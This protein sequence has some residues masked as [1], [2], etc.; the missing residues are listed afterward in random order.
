MKKLLTIS[1]ILLASALIF[2]GCTQ[3]TNGE[4]PS[5]NPG[6]G[7]WS[8]TA[9]WYSGTYGPVFENADKTISCG[10]VSQDGQGGAV[11]TN[12]NPVETQTGS[13]VLT[14]STFRSNA[15]KIISDLDITGFEGTAKCTSEHS[16]YGYD[17]YVSSDWSNYYELF[18]WGSHFMLKKRINNTNSIIQNWTSS[19]AIKAE[20]S[21]NKITVY[22]DGNAIKILINGTNVYTINNPEIT[23]GTVAYI[24]GISYEDI[25]NNTNITATYK[26]TNLQR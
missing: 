11:Y 9:N 24:C 7:N 26:V 21:E 18:L 5:T 8:T 10:S 25:H 23:S 3:P 6:P 14:Q 20:P 13:N 15:Y 4:N 17:F 1:A 22:K 16:T 12:T 19:S 2:T